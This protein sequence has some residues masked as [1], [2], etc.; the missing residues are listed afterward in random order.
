MAPENASALALRSISQ[1]RRGEM[2][3]AFKDAEAALEV[4]GEKDLAVST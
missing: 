3:A 4:E 2:R 1:E